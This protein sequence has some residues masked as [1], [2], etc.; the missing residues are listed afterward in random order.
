MLKVLSSGLWKVVGKKARL[1]GQRSAAIA[2]V[3]DPGLL[4]LKGGDRLVVDASNA[5]IAAGRTSAKVLKRYFDDGVEISCLPDLHAKILVIDD[6]AVIGSANASANSEAVYFEAAVLSDRPE[7]VGQAEKLLTYL[8]SAGTPVDEAFIERILRIPVKKSP[9][10]SARVP[11]RR[12]NRPSEKQRFWL[13]SLLEN[14]PYPGDE[15]LVDKITE[16]V[17]SKLSSRAGFVDWFWTGRNGRLPAEARV[18]DIVIE[19]LRPKRGMTTTRG[20]RVYGH[21]RIARIFQERGAKWKTYHCIWRADTGRSALSWG[22][23]SRL[24]KRAGITRKITFMSTVE[25][26][27]QQSSALFELWP[28]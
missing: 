11:A 24:R 1:A 23:F 16:E 12:K 8:E 7:L 21:G 18:G 10:V 25:L 14:A 22:E 3:T 26:S 19:C 5:S 13:V 28:R 20:I 6:W 27:E 4:R 2:Y 9:R 15:E 17:E